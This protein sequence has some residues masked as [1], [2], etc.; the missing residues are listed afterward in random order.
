MVISYMFVIQLVFPPSIKA[1]F[2]SD[3]KTR[4]CKN[5]VMHAKF[6]GLAASMMR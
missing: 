2:F 1:L 3:F 5:T 6:P 4:Q